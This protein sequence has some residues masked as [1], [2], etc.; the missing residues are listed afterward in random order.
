M[1]DL[2]EL[3]LPIELPAYPITQYWHARYHNDPGTVWMRRLV[4]ELY[5]QGG[6][7]PG[8]APADTGASLLAPEMP[9]SAE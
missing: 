1:M 3:P 5:A 2:E 4:Y 8:C 7:A 6:E 9:A